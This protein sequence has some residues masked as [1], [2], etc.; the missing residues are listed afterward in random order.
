L[1]F[2]TNQIQIP[3]DWSDQD[4]FGHV[5]NLAIL[6][7]AQTAR[8]HYLEAIG[9]MQAHGASGIGPV[10]ASTSCQFRRQLF[11]P[12]Q[13]TVRTRVDQVNNTSFHM[14]HQVL[15]G[16]RE[17]V[18]EMHDVLV[19]FDYRKNAKLRVPEVFRDRMAAA[20]PVAAGAAEG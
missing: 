11:Y 15:D 16:A 8:V 13:V 1:D 20:E 10:L 5:N 4:A 12:G 14:R 9:M 17:V 2:R 6:R 3:I 7:Y 18:A 19:M